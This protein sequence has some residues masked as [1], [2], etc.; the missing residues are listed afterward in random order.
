LSNTPTVKE[1]CLEL[2]VSGTRLTFTKSL[3]EVCV[4]GPNVNL[5]FSF[6]S[7]E[8]ATDGSRLT[9]IGPGVMV[10]DSALT[11][12]FDWTLRDICVTHSP[13]LWRLLT[14]TSAKGTT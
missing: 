11:R 10:T 2:D 12:F 7:A 14:G 8:F 13:A 5:T 1:L 6:P 4:R 3:D 9:Q